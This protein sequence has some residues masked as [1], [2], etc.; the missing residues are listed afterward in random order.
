MENITR[1]QSKKETKT[2]LT[3]R[4]Y[5]CDHCGEIIITKKSILARINSR[6]YVYCDNNECC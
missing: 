4:S 6:T 2:I 1:K 3:Q 5:I